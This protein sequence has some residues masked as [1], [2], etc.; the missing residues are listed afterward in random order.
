MSRDDEAVLA[1]FHDMDSAFERGEADAIV[2]LFSRDASMTFWGSATAE[3]ALGR[4]AL[5]EMLQ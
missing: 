4:D 5:R 1:T 2:D 3:E